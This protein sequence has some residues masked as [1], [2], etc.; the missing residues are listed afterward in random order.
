MKRLLVAVVLCGLGVASCS[1]SEAPPGENPLTAPVDYLGAAAKAK[2][3]SERTIDTIA[4]N[5][6]VQLFHASEGRYPHDLRELVTRKYLP[7]I[8]TPPHG[9]K[10]IYD[11]GTG[12]VRIVPESR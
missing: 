12:Q 9:M 7:R 11:A 6:A 10:L 8:P 3:A 4:L 2:Q 1:R 5:Q